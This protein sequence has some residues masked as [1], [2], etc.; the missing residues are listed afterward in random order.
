MNHKE[1]YNMKN[2]RLWDSHFVKIKT[3]HGRTFDCDSRIAEVVVLLNNKGYT[4]MFSCEGHPFRYVESKEGEFSKTRKLKYDHT[5]Y[6]DGGYLMFFSREDAELVYQELNKCGDYFIIG[7]H[8]NPSQVDKRVID[9]NCIDS[10][11]LS[12]YK[13]SIMRES[14]VACIM[15]SLCE[16]I[17][18]ILLTVAKALPYKEEKYRHNFCILQ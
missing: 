7:V 11:N 4:T 18:D 3:E 16:E 1:C 8:K 15:R 17:W 9:W 6:F 2:E 5:F 13:R 12:I 14:S 10:V